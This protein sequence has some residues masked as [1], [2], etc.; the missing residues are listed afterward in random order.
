[1][2]AARGANSLINIS[3]SALGTGLD[4][5]TLQLFPIH[6]VEDVAIGGELI[7][8]F[9]SKPEVSG[10]PL[11]VRH[12]KQNSLGSIRTKQQ[13]NIHDPRRETNPER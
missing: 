3:L 7:A 1:M 13:I 5:D 11:L 12:H 9:A 6:S 2:V 10:C 8:I 4:Q